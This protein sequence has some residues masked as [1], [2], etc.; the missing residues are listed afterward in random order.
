MKRVLALALALGL[1]SP[2]A[3]VGCGEE[4]K[5]KETVTTSGPGGTTTE[6]KVD[7]INQTGE[8][9]PPPTGTSDQPAPK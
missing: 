9:P 2:V 7:K 8:N 6:T 5:Q 4:T 1:I 3:F